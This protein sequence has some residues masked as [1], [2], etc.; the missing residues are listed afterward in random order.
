MTE[1]FVKAAFTGGVLAPAFYGRSDMEKFDLGIRQGYNWWVDYRGGISVRPPLEFCDYIKEDDKRVRLMSFSFNND[2]ANNYI[3]I[4]GDRYVAFAR[5]GAYITETAKTATIAAGVNTTVTSAAHGF[6]NGDW[7]KLYGTGLPYETFE[8]K[9]VTANTFQL[10]TPFGV[11]MNSVGYSFSGTY[12]LA[13]IYMLPSPYSAGSLLRLT[14]SQYRD[15]LYITSNSYPRKKLIRTSDASWAFEDV[16]NVP[17]IPAPVATAITSSVA[18][19]AGVCYAV[20]AVDSNGEESLLSNI[21]LSETVVFMP[22]TAG[23]I[24][25]TWNAVAGAIKYRVYRSLLTIVGASITKGETLGYLGETLSTSFVDTNIIPDFTKTPPTYDDP[26]ADGAVLYIDITAGGSG[27]AKTGTTVNLSGGTG[28]SGEVIVDGGEIVGVRIINPGT[29]YTGG[30]VTFSGAGTGA[31][32]TLSASP[33]SGNNPAASLLT[34]QRRVYAGTSNLP[35]SIYGSR[36]R[37]QDNF[38]YDYLAVATDPFDLSIDSEEL[39]PIKHLMPVDLGFMVF[40]GGAVHQVLGANDQSINADNATQ[41]PIT[42]DGCA[43]VAPLRVGDHIIYVIR[44]SAGVNSI[45]PSNLRNYYELADR[46]LFSN[47]YFTGE[48]RVI[49]WAFAKVPFRQ[50]W[51]VRQDGTM[52][53]CTYVPDQNVYAWTDHGT[54]GFAHSVATAIEANVNTVY[55]VVERTVNGVVKKFFER[56]DSYIINSEEDMAAVDAYTETSLTPGAGTISVS[57]STGTGVTITSAD[58][59]FTADMVDKHLRV[60]HGRI[61]ITAY[62]DANNLVGDVELPLTQLYPETQLPIASSQWTIDPL[63]EEVTGLGHLEGLTVSLVADGAQQPDVVVTDGVA[64]LTQPASHVVVGLNYTALFETL[65]LYSTSQVIIDKKKRVVSA[66]ARLLNARGLQAASG[67]S[68]RFYDIKIRTFEPFNA[69]P[70]RANGIYEFHVT[71]N[72]MEDATFMLRKN[73]P[74]KATVSGFVL[75]VEPGLD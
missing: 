30:A 28:F 31:T 35:M 72:F 50:A 59:P 3:L 39:T 44:G 61:K 41:R 2:S 48:N 58:A 54:L 12:S 56:M 14:T 5:D 65:P 9:S 8:V 53:S 68:D 4:F 16:E 46:S 24:T 67:G 32:A 36:P 64:A 21:M 69:P 70:M 49:A 6:S 40:T 60:N 62:V 63:V 74:F 1:P 23:E 55:F 25:F 27:Y 19:T 47:H 26:F 13:R 66:S 71:G 43:N 57:A 45:Q 15:V 34:Q 10:T 29:G 51:V 7:I 11:P 33:A 75:D 22:T 73:G 17:S 52:L 18:G 42:D 37:F 20:T 38:N